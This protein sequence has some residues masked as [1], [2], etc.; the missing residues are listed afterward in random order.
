VI[1][2]T[3]KSRKNFKLLSAAVG[4]S[5]VV[6]LGALSLAIDHEN[7]GTASVA[8]S[9][10]NVGQTSTETTAPAAP[11]VSMAVPTIKGPAPL[12]PEQQ[13]AI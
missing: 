2:V 11:V 9:S 5:A 10:M 3:S 6:A 8:G 13:A 1:Q 7:A 12:P 4:G